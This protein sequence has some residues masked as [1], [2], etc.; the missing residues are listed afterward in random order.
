HEVFN[1]SLGAPPAT[2]SITD[3]FPTNQL[4]SVV[5]QNL[6]DPAAFLLLPYRLQHDFKQGRTDYARLGRI[7]N[8]LISAGVIADR[9]NSY[10]PQQRGVA[11]VG[12]VV[13][14]NVN[15]GVGWPDPRS[16]RYA[17][18]REIPKP[19]EHGQIVLQSSSQGEHL[20][21]K[22]V[23]SFKKDPG[24]L[25]GRSLLSVLSHLGGLSQDYRRQFLGKHIDSRS[26]PLFRVAE[27]P[28]WF[29]ERSNE[30]I[31]SKRGLEYIR[32]LEL[33]HKESIMALHELAIAFSDDC[34]EK[35]WES[36]SQFRA[37]VN[38]AISNSLVKMAGCDKAD[39][40]TRPVVGEVLHALQQST[41][42]ASRYLLVLLEPRLCRRVSYGSDD[43]YKRGTFTY[44]D[45]L[46]Y[47]K[48][49]L[50]S[51]KSKSKLV[52][53][54]Y[55]DAVLR[56]VDQYLTEMML[57]QNANFRQFPSFY[58][59]TASRDGLN[60]ISKGAIE[61]RHLRSFKGAFVAVGCSAQGYGENCFCLA[62]WQSAWGAKVPCTH[63]ELA[64]RGNPSQGD[65]WIG[66]AEGIPVNN[67]VRLTGLCY[68]STT[69]PEADRMRLV[70]DL[71]D[72]AGI[73]TN[74]SPIH[75]TGF[76][77]FISTALR[78]LLGVCYPYHWD[79]PTGVDHQGRV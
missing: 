20:A 40:K 61:V 41:D 64:T 72:K 53:G 7:T 34:G 22:A 78:D 77:N 13:Q 36:A 6:A 10:Q 19:I 9:R 44:E 52:V 60:G 8:G 12:Q 30:K 1:W 14:A 75:S 15:P 25:R 16:A 55:D 2:S 21:E 11:V 37:E 28:E 38:E 47:L 74:L 5:D 68:I 48:M 49:R 31:E 46:G 23:E 57:P 71:A 62:P 18:M 69:I 67:K 33:N 63:N 39:V 76:R 66:F 56:E 79:H 43:T 50:D 24:K 70:L 59:C 65:A 54:Q 4:A 45:M 51:H 73:D 26:I 27:P 35:H 3:Y 29:K 42:L 58:H 32:S 17:L